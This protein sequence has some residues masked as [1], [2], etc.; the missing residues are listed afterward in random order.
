MS[1]IRLIIS[2]VRLSISYV[3]P[4]NTNS[5]VRLSTSYVRLSNTISYIRLIISY[6]R[7]SNTVSYVRLSISYVQHKT[8]FFFIWQQYASVEFFISPLLLFH[9]QKVIKS[10]SFTFRNQCVCSAN[11]PLMSLRFLACILIILSDELNKNHPKLCACIY[12]FSIPS[13]YLCCLDFP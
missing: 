13:F 4:S 10:C 2:Y 3:R 6:V 12:K 11:L 5:Y 7:L 1:Y 8:P 9:M